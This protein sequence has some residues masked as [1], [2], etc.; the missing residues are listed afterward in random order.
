MSGCF[1]PDRLLTPWERQL[2]S[3]YTAP[4]RQGRMTVWNLDD[5]SPAAIRALCWPRVGMQPSR[6][7]RATGTA[8]A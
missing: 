3:A 7:V 6:L 5:L 1:V 8:E 2:V 4:I